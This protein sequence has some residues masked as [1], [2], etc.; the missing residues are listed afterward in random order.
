MEPDALPA[1]PRRIEGVLL[2]LDGVLF[3]GDS[4][5]PAALEFV[6]ALQGL[7]HAFVTNNPIR[8]SA[9]IAD[10]LERLGFERPDPRIIVTSAEATATWLAREH[11]GFRYYAVGAE[12]LHLAL[13]AHGQADAGQADFVVIGEGPGLDFDSLTLGINLILQGAT[14]VATNPDTTVDAE[15]DGK[16]FVAPGGGALVAPFA[17]ATGRQP[18]II[19]KPNPL[20][21]RMALQRIGIA[22]GHCLMIGD[23]P[24]TDLAGATALG[25]MTALVRSGRF[26]PGDAWPAALP[27]PDWDVGSLR[28][29]IPLLQG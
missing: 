26:A 17:A 27:E 24:D 6:A 3:R 20:L 21:Y 15:T 29:L 9:A 18:V 23:R 5:I 8:P 19:G 12:G 11:P 14:L 7:P 22:P 25:M 10:K 13:A 4:V 2:D 1:P 16:R 28:P